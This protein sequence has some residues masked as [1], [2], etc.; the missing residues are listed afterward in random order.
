M[1]GRPSAGLRREPRDHGPAPPPASARARPDAR[2]GNPQVH[3]LFNPSPGPHP[4]LRLVEGIA[5]VW[6]KNAPPVEAL[7]YSG[8][9]GW[10]LTKQPIYVGNPEDGYR[11]VPDHFA[12]T[13]AT[14]GRALGVVGHTYRIYLQAR[15]M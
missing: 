14:D 13:R 10:Q 6:N 11:Q 9:A 4:V 3:R 12:V 5:H 8:L 7:T 1:L 15:V 2:D